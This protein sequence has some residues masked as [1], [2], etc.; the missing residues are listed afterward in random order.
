MRAA[1][2]HPQSTQG[3]EAGLPLLPPLL[4][5]LAHRPALRRILGK[6]PFLRGHL[7]LVIEA[8][9]ARSTP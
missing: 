2:P 4:R 3:V 1:C 5:R 8:P 7:A 9:E 6:L